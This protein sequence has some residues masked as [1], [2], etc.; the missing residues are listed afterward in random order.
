MI[1]SEAHSAPSRV[2]D[3]GSLVIYRF[4][5]LLVISFFTFAPHSS[6]AD[7]P[8]L[9]SAERIKA[10][11]AFLASDRLEGRGP[12]TRGEEL[13]TEYLSNELKKAAREE[14]EQ[15]LRRAFA[16]R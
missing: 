5:P 16:D 11:I 3:E 15:L 13:T 14:L 12:G 6:A 2:R 4:L 7:E 1:E 8:P 9:I 10:D